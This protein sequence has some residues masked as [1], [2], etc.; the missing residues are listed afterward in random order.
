MQEIAYVNGVFCPMEQA[1]VSINDRGFQYGDSVYEVIAAYGGRPFRMADHLHR[2]GTS[3][4]A[5]RIEL[6]L[7]TL[8]IESLVREGLTRCGFDEAMAYIQITRGVAPRTHI[9]PPGIKPT[10][11]MTFRPLP[12]V[13]AP[14]KEH[15]VALMTA[16]EIRW[17]MCYVKATTL[18]PNVLTRMDAR[19][20]GFHDAIFVAPDGDVREGTSSNVV[21]V[22]G[23]RLVFP[24][25]DASILH[26]VTLLT[27][28]QCA[29]HLGIACEERPVHI[30]ELRA[31]DEMFLTST[32]EEV[33]PVTSLDGRPIA[34]GQ[35]GAITRR[36]MA[37]YHDLARGL[38]VF[39]DRRRNS[40]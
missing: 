36:M 10:V 5:L 31:A 19:A 30:D 4:S 24:C 3:L 11:V 17:A 32:T 29:E 37:T 13:S 6:D 39:Q 22:R 38:G 18:L 34:D 35:V 15:G 21:M 20:G 1:T 26:G 23:G 14:A 2:L 27:V 7:T 33:L 28:T 9:A 16:A 25:R 8:K 12:Q 40:A